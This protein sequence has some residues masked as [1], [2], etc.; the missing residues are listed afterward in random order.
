MRRALL[1]VRTFQNIGM[2]RKAL[3]LNGRQKFRGWLIRAPSSGLIASSLRLPSALA[4]MITF[5]AGFTA[6]ATLPMT[7]RYINGRYTRLISA[8]ARSSGRES[9]SKEFRERNAT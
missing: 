1:K 4:G 8:A 2:G 7:G 9:H 3:M 5:D 6:T